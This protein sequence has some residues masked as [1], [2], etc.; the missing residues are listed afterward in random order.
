MPIAAAGI[1]LAIR[2][3]PA[4]G[5]RRPNGRGALDI[6]GI[7]L[8]AA[9]LTALLLFLMRLRT[10]PPYLLLGAAI[11]ILAALVW[12]ELRRVEPFL[13]V[14][15]LAGNRALT[16][17]YVR[18]ALNWLVVYSVMYGFSQW[19]EEGRG[20]S[21]GVTGLVTLPMPVIGTLAAVFVSRRNLVRGPMLAGTAAMI[22]GT[23][24]LTLLHASS[25]LV[26]LVMVTTLLGVPQ[27]LNPVANQAALYRQVPAG[28]TG[29]A[30]GL[31]RTSQYLG[32]ILQS[33]LVGAVYGSR[34]DDPAL[35]HLAP[36]L[37]ALGTVLLLI[38]LTDRGLRSPR[39]EAR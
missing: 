12:W 28:R 34:A 3:L 38:T 14:R 25:P 5:P 32:A 35:H 39:P 8:F 13:D 22:A 1:V 9:G 16:M 24:A 26:V 36:M 19:L 7:V 10:H 31:L 23:S 20:L 33:S 15:M 37:A 30:A 17:T 11:V 4:D 27:G 18:Y 2:W 21:P 29:S 6:T